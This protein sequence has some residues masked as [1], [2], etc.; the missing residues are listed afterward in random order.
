MKKLLL[1]EDNKDN[2]EL[3]EFVLE[4]ETDWEINAISDGIK[5]IEIAELEQPDAILLD[6]I[7]PKIDGLTVCNV[8]G[9]NLFTCNIPVIFI[10]AMVD[11][12]S[13]YL[14]E[15]THALGIITKPLD[16]NSLATKIKEICKW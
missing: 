3:V 16:I 11:N 12:K 6:F 13:Y 2:R 14:L 15:N 8:L 4:T 10:T 5:G 7:M 1:I 9:N